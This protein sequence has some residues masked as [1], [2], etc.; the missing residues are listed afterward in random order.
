[1]VRKGTTNYKLN[2]DVEL[3]GRKLVEIGFHNTM[4]DLVEYAVMCHVLKL[5]TKINRKG[6]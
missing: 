6:D 4:T 3:R 5:E 1:M 2:K